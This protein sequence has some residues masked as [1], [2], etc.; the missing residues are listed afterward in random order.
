MFVGSCFRLTLRSWIVSSILVLNGISPSTDWRLLYVPN[1]CCQQYSWP[2]DIVLSS[3][4][5][6]SRQCHDI[7][8][9]FCMPKN[10]FVTDVKWQ[11]AA[12]SDG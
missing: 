8:G 7:K 12:G 2:S 9:Q 6:M 1:L 10:I 4:C 11:R 5:V 3:S